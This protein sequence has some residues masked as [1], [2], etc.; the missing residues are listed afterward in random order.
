MCQ[1]T[2]AISTDWTFLDVSSPMLIF[3]R[4]FSS[5]SWSTC[6]IIINLSSIFNFCTH[7]NHIHC[8]IIYRVVILCRTI[9]TMLEINIEN[10][11]STKLNFS[12]MNNIDA[13]R[14]YCIILNYLNW[15]S[16]YFNFWKQIPLW[17]T[18]TYHFLSKFCVV[19]AKFIPILDKN[20][21]CHLLQFFITLCL[22]NP[23]LVIKK[24]NKYF[25]LFYDPKTKI[26]PNTT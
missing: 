14:F 4:S 9:A 7:I 15:C 20:K 24:K 2:G 1:E 10:G 22:N 8:I 6:I 18:S 13:A 12:L 3:V 5:F 21:F 26:T 23:Y 16:I 11:A 17:H 19:L 25:W